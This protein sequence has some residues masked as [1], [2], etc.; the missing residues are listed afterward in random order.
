[1]TQNKKYAV[2]GGIGSGK[3]TFCSVLEEMGYPVFSCDGIYA[4]LWHEKEYI[5]LLREHFPDCFCGEIPV[6]ARL[7]QKVFSD[8]NQLKKLNRL[9][10]PLIMERLFT[11]MQKYPVS[12]AEVPLLFEGGY[13]R[14]FDGVIALQ[15]DPEERIHSVMARDGITEEE[16]LAR[17]ANQADAGVY[18]E[19]KC[20][21]VVNDG[22][23]DSLRQKAKDVINRLGVNI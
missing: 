12:F 2:T 20:I 22:S 3:S 18:S 8:K 1:M 14:F 9:A 21:V 16:T 19:K 6:K 17:M 5:S 15:R 13:E 11:Q 7:A 4:D 10:H 23:V